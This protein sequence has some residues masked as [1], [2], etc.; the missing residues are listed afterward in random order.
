MHFVCANETDNHNNGKPPFT[1]T[2]VEATL[3]KCLG[4][5]N[6]REPPILAFDILLVQAK[7]HKIEVDQV[8]CMP[9]KHVG[10]VLLIHLKVRSV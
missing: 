9:E 5:M 8:R 4:R 10:A 1:A 2:N 6:L 3:A 7:L